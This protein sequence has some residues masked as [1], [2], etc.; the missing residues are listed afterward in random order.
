MKTLPAARPTSKMS[1]SSGFTIVELVV[2]IVIAGIIIPA[3]AI[4]LQNLTSVEYQARDLALANMLSQNKIESLRS[5][6]Y[7][8]VSTG[9]TDFSSELPLSMGAP[10]SASYTVST[11][12]TGIKQIDL[13]IS[14]TEYKISR[15]VVFK[16]YI[17]ELGVGQ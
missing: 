4:A 17:S 6:G 5:I 9:T 1:K 14:Y 12:Q 3:V 11:P 7:N 15:T 8:S 13:S 16:S 10:K 2:T